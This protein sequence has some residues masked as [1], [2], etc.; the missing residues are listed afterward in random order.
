MNTNGR[1]FKTVSGDQSGAKP[2]GKR[3]ISVVVDNS[4]EHASL[5]SLAPRKRGHSRRARYRNIE[6]LKP[7]QVDGLHAADEAAKQARMPLNQFVT[8]NWLLSEHGKLCPQA[9]GRCRNRM[10][11]W[12]RDKGA[13]VAWA[14]VHENPLSDMGDAMP[15][16][17]LLVHCPQR[18]QK[19]F[20]AKLPDWFDEAADGATHCR[21]RGNPH[22]DKT[23]QYMSKGADRFTCKRNGGFRKEGGQG[24]I[25]CKRSGFS[26]SLHSIIKAA[27]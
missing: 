11:Q 14:Y 10:V 22:R 16:T 21:G 17:H 19:M 4:G 20:R 25:T 15:N 13:K 18:L 3:A 23:L 1:N 2:Y 5:Y 7:W 9:F 27:S 26:Q 8:V 24:T 12:L 6:N